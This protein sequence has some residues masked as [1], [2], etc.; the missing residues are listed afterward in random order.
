MSQTKFIYQQPTK[1]YF[2]LFLSVG[3]FLC[4]FL[5]QQVIAAFVVALIAMAVVLW[6]HNW[7]KAR[8]M[9]LVM[10]ALA[11]WSLVIQ[12]LGGKD[13]DVQGLIDFLPRQ[14]N[15]R[16]LFMEAYSKGPDGTTKQMIALIL[17]N[18]R[19]RSLN[20]FYY[21]LID[22][23]IVHLFVV[24]G[25]HLSLLNLFVQKICPKKWKFKRWLGL[26]ITT[27][28]ALLLGMS[29]GVMRVIFGLCR[30]TLNFDRGRLAYLQETSA[31]GFYSLCFNP[32]LILDLGFQ[33][34]YLACLALGISRCYHKMPELVTALLNS[35][36]INLLVG[37]I[38]LAINGEINLLTIF[39]GWL[40]SP[41]ISFFYLLSLFLLPLPFIWN[42]FNWA[43]DLLMQN[44][45][46]LIHVSFFFKLNLNTINIWA[47]ISYYLVF[48]GLWIYL[49]RMQQK[50]DNDH[51]SL[52]RSHAHFAL[53]AA[54]AW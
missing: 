10:A 53:L 13:L 1:Q 30:R 16:A 54:K 9:L 46:T 40:L 36:L 44:M 35:F 4:L 49:Y 38:N 11:I 33:L 37:P 20:P 7:R 19:D 3:S 22:L 29:A 26:I 17:F 45:A 8:T 25:M 32:W 28:Y 5:Q 31:A 12:M 47:Q 39:W 41:I 14:M 51:Y 48:F 34:S 50:P 6:I 23:G 24:S 27:I 21:N 52:P 43:Y 15:L 2:S 18:N 42:G